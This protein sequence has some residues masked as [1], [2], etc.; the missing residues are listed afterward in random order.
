[1]LLL[2]SRVRICFAHVNM[3]KSMQLQ[4]FLLTCGLRVMLGDLSN[5]PFAI[6]CSILHVCVFFTPG[7][8]SH[9]FEAGTINDNEQQQHADATFAEL[10][11]PQFIRLH[12]FQ[13]IVERSIGDSVTL[14]CPAVGQP[15]PTIAWSKDGSKTPIM[16]D[17]VAEEPAPIRYR[18]FAMTLDDLMA[19]DSGNYT[20]TVCNVNNCITFTTELL[21]IGKDLNKFVLL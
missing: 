6:F 3:H 2:W 14:K 21:V 8:M 20:C 1:M 9:D 15:I 12:R 18:K 10:N 17:I 4:I 13:S 19:A 5:L 16:R 7:D 11:T